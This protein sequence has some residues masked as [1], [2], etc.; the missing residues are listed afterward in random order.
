MK[1][2]IKH[3]FKK[4][5]AVFSRILYYAMI[6][7]ACYIITVSVPARI[8]HS[9]IGPDMFGP[10]HEQIDEN[11]FIFGYRPVFVLTGSM[12]PYML[13]NSI[14]ITK[15]VTDISELAVGDVVSYHVNTNDG[16]TLRITH[17]I[18]DIEGEF[19]YTKG[20]NNN[21]PDGYPLTMDNI[22]AKVTSVFN[23][24]PWLIDKW[25]SGMS[26]KILI[27][28]FAIA[29]ILFFMTIKSV[30]QSFLEDENDE[31]N[32]ESTTISLAPF[33]ID[34]L[35]WAVS[36]GVVVFTHYNAWGFIKY[37]KIEAAIAGVFVSYLIGK[38]IYAAIKIKKEKSAEETL[39]ENNA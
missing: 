39:V 26:G 13:T 15:E 28:S 31:E 33:I 38:S 4:F 22:E 7:L 1:Q 3:Y 16:D 12:E 37:V 8:A 27:V 6:F 5:D 29:V 21:V 35:V 17:R 36:L 19:I 24:L 2:K 9:D 32:T 25:N 11:T 10:V 18:T 30:V 20:D 34:R 14:I 23:Q